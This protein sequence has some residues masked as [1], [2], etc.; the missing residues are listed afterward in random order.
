MSKNQNKIEERKKKVLEAKLTSP[1][2]T[3]REIAKDV[4]ATKSTIDR[5]LRALGQDGAIQSD[6]TINAIKDADLEIVILGQSILLER[7]QDESERKNIK[8]RDI[9]T[10]AKDSQTRYSFLAGE[11]ANKDGG[12]KYKILDFANVIL[13][14]DND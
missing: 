3:Q 9:S 8:A 5:D 2:K 12:E 13:D 4:G 7:F 14:E 11:N 10:I 1:S 6:E